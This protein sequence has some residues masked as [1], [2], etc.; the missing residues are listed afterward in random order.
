MSQTTR[1]CVGIRQ[2]RAAIRGPA[3]VS[4]RTGGILCRLSGLAGYEGLYP[5]SL[6]GFVPVYLLCYLYLNW[7]VVTA[8]AAPSITHHPSSTLPL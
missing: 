5:T 6:N 1:L 8:F 4:G 3:P 7:L 2:S